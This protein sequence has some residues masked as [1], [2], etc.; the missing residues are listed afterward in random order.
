MLKE[1]FRQPNSVLD[2]LRGRIDPETKEVKLGGLMDYEK[3]LTNKIE[4]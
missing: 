2:T 1:I 3:K 4:L